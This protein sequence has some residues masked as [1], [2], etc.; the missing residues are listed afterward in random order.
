MRVA[1]VGS[2]GSGKSTFARRLGEAAAIPHFELDAINWQPGWRDLTT[3]DLATFIARVEEVAA[4]EAWVT[5]GN[6]SKVLPRILARATDVVW[7]D[8]DRSVIM[9]RV[10]KRSFIRSWT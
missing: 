9:P 10:L 8:Y 3:H 5:D 6:Y 2:S 1:V 7:L 4:G